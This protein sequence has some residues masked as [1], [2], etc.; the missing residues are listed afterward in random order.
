MALSRK[1]KI[2]LL[3]LALPIAACDSNDDSDIAPDLIREITIVSPVPN[4][5]DGNVTTTLTATLFLPEKHQN[6]QPYPLILHS[7]S[8][9][10]SRVSGDEYRATEP[11]DAS[12]PA[13]YGSLVDSQIVALREGGYA[14]ISYDQRGFGR[15]DDG[16]NGSDGGS[17]GMSPDF[18]IEDAKAVLDW[19]VANLNLLEDSPGDPKVGMMG[20]SYGGAFQP[21]LAAEDPRVDAIVPSITWY[22]LQE[23]FAPNNV[24][25]KAWLIALCDKVVDE[26][27]A[28]L[29]AEMELAC[30]QVRL[31]D[32]REI[33]DA[34]ITESLFF[35][36][37]PAAYDADPAFVM[38]RVDALILQGVRDTLFPLN[39][40]LALHEFLLAGGG[41][42][43]LLAHESGHSGV[44]SGTGSQGEIGQ[45]YCGDIDVIT[46]IKRWFDDKLLAAAP[47]AL[48]RICV[49]LDNQRAIHLGS[50]PA[51]DDTHR[52][53]M[54][55][56]TSV[57]GSSENN[58]HSAANEALF[59]TL[60]QI[61]DSNL[62]LLGTP[63]ARLVVEAAP[64]NSDPTPLTGPNAA[65]LFVGIGI[66]RDNQL[67]LVDDQV[68]PILSTDERTDE[69][70]E[71]I[72][73]VAVA[74]KLE[75]GDRVGVLIY[76]KHDLYENHPIDDTDGIGTNWQDNVA[77]FFGV[78]DLPI[79]E[80]NTIDERP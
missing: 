70:P 39:E 48:P 77:T 4:D 19:A 22:N 73:L 15:G 63:V 40:G 46:A 1:A 28:Q 29:S 26:D 47:L 52:V 36:N 57:F 44:R 13:H 33:N 45:P 51:T 2:A 66:L 69:T 72:P 55:P 21:M 64:T 42:V 38:P 5:S 80:V 76:G 58:I 7:H 14:V 16:D 32:S 8:W 30:T 59:Y 10:G 31:P 60:P 79:V 34:R 50:M 53:T 68:Q 62:A 12:T 11:G 71:P 9:G 18:E 20:N 6:G 74:E 54:T 27:G 3:A 49:A 56:L 24:L 65:G 78:V 75:V 23:A 37:S 25:K 61:T 41:D 43:R 35:D 17:H 67:F